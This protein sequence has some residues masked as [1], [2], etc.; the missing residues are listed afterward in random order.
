MDIEV[1]TEKF[2]KVVSCASRASS[3]KVVQPILNNILL[4]S[5]KGCLMVSATDLDL[6]IECKNVEKLRSLLNSLGYRDQEKESSTEWNFALASGSKDI[7]VHVFEFDDKGNNIEMNH[8]VSNNQ[9]YRIYQMHYDKKGNMKSKF[10]FDKD[11]K[12]IEL[13]IY[14]YQF[15]QGI[16]SDHTIG[17]K[18]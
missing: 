8:Y 15:Y 2:K 12:I 4:S 5:E 9:L 10:T 16:H 1:K 13:T 3:N 7:D 6:A 18:Q 17:N 11:E 14:V